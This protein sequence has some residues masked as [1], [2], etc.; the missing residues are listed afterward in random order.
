MPYKKLKRSRHDYV[1]CGVCGGLGDYFEIDPI[2]FRL[3]FIISMLSFGIGGIPYL[4]MW[5]ITEEE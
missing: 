3:I 2:I 5:F 1:C 4:I